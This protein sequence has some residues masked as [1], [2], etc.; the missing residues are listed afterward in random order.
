MNQNKWLIE[1]EENV[2]VTWWF[3]ELHVP[4]GSVQIVGDALDL[5]LLGQQIVLDLIDPYVQPLDVH[6]GIFGSGLGG[7]EPLHQIMDLLLVSLLPLIG[8]FFADLKILEKVGSF[9]NIDNAWVQLGQ[10]VDGD[11][12]EFG[13]AVS[14]S[15]DGTV[16]AA[17]SLSGRGTVQTFRFNEQ[18]RDWETFGRELVGEEDEDRFGRSLSLSSD[19]RILAV[20]AEWND[21]AGVNSSK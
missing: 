18:S 20:G 17:S 11:K 2:N 3:L 16:F 7:L 10:D 21:V 6:L 1:Q 19:G 4:E 13:S 9:E 15:G 5:E 14:L 8:L 12:N